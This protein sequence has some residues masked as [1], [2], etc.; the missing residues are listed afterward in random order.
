MQKVSWTNLIALLSAPCALVAAAPFFGAAHWTL[1]LMACFVVQAGAALALAAALYSL[2]RKW[3]HAS[4]AA[5]FATLAAIAVVPDWLPERRHPQPVE[6]RQHLVFVAV[7]LLS[8]NDQGEERVLEVLREAAA[9]VVWFSEYT[10][11]WQPLLRAGLPDFP[12]RLERPDLGSFGAALYSRHPLEDAALVPGGHPW[13]PFGRATLRSPH[14]LIGLLGVH[15]PP[16]LPNPRGVAERDAGLAA[17]A[18]LLDGLPPRRVVFGDF[19]AT[20][21][22]RAFARMRRDAGLSLGSTAWWLPSWPDPMPALLRTPIDH[23]L[24]SGDLEVTEAAL[25]A[26]IG[27]DHRP[28]VAKVRVG[29]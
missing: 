2:G 19:N 4:A 27:S 9:D 24:T 10:P 18:P 13:S 25:G 8:S 16:P 7:N 20:P 29:G 3:A 6:N 17:I 28:I 22:N 11:A 5:A 15:P 14:G 12:H 1:D 26:S 23:V 21:W